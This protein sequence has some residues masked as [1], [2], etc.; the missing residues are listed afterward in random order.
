MTESIFHNVEHLH[1][2][3]T[4]LCNASCPSCPRNFSNSFLL[5]PGL[6]LNTWT[7]EDFKKR[8]PPEFLTSVDHINFCGNHGDPVACKELLGILEYLDE[9][10]VRVIEMHSNTG[11]K[12]AATWSKIGELF[13]RNKDWVMI[14]S[15]DGLE[16]TNHLYRRNVKWNKVEQN[17]KAFTQHGGTS[18]WDFLVFKHNEHQIEE[19]KQLSKDWG[20]KNFTP[21]IPANVDTGEGLQRMPAMNNE[22]YLDYYIEASTNPKYR[23]DVEDENLISTLNLSFE[24]ENYN[25][26]MS[27]PEKDISECEKHDIKP[28][29][30]DNVKIVPKCKK[31]HNTS[32]IY[33]DAN[34]I[35]M[36][37]CWVGLYTPM[38][39]EFKMTGHILGHETWQLYDM[40]EKAGGWDKL[41]LN[42]YSIEEIIT[43]GVLQ[44]VFEDKWDK[45]VAEGKS[46]ICA[47]YCG[48]SNIV[49]Q[50]YTSDEIE[51]ERYN[52]LKEA[53]REIKNERTNS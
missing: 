47:N 34:G 48:G 12:T 22:G 25:R 41:D 3:L 50:I 32:S 24:P 35:V 53:W 51:S 8:L 44:E 30:I 18:D 9:I 36:P 45:T 20:V 26:L 42:K 33:I 16:D 39:N 23:P 11:A 52:P 15:I 14:F 31:S 28:R 29:D 2:E 5:R 46:S 10:N 43:S 7:L 40:V 37:C 4:N 49:D 6:K 19:V 13:A 17:I 38:I 27:Q 1:I 21:K